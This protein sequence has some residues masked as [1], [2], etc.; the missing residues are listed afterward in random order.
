VA[1]NFTLDLSTIQTKIDQS[2]DKAHSYM[3][4]TTQYNSMRAETYSRINARW[5]DRS[6]N[7]RS[8]LTGTY[9][10]E[11]RAKGASYSVEL[12]HKVNYG[13]W[14]EIRFNQKYAI[15]KKTLEHQ[16]PEFFRMATEVMNRMF[17]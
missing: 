11:T 16:S 15:I 10:A 5:I 4:K 13:I 14:L 3:T 1:S 8:G 6:T 7:A 2:N 9:K 12:F 17:D